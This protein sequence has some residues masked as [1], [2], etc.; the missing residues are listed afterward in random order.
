LRKRPLEEN[1]SAPADLRVNINALGRECIADLISAVVDDTNAKLAVIETGADV[2]N[3]DRH[4]LVALVVQRADV[5]GRTDLLDR[6]ANPFE[7]VDGSHDVLHQ[8]G[9]IGSGQDQNI[10]WR[11]TWS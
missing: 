8:G 3:G 4:F 11:R 1:Q 7:A 2:R 9:D 5:I 6:S 10:A